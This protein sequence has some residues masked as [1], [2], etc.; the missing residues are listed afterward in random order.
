MTVVET[1]PRRGAPM[2]A[3]TTC[4]PYAHLIAIG[5]KSVENR[6]WAT[7]YRGPLAIHAGKSRA[8]MGDSLS[9]FGIELDE[10]VFGAVVAVAKLTD[11]LHIDAIVRGDYDERHPWLRSHAHT[12]GEWCW[13][14]ESVRK[15]EAPIF[16]R[17]AQGLWNFD[18]SVLP[19]YALS[20]FA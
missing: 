1:C 8:W 18:S 14:L 4:Q 10:L 13:V 7:S 11:V 6:T 3:L 5:Q 12:E 2:K 17:G 19:Q 20:E 16:W 15:L 9:F